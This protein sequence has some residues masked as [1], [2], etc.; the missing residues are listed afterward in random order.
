[1]RQAI[2]RIYFCVVYTRMVLN[3]YNHLDLHIMRHSFSLPKM[4]RCAIK[5]KHSGIV[6]CVLFLCGLSLLAM[7]LREQRGAHVSPCI[8]I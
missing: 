3:V 6:A 4:E 7:S 2:K 5:V 8:N 1:M